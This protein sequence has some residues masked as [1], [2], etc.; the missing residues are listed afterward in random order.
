[1]FESMIAALEVQHTVN[2]LKASKEL[3]KP[4]A[5]PASVAKARLAI[6]QGCPK[7]LAAVS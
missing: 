3:A 6:L 7:R 2:F 5:S 1:M 4:M